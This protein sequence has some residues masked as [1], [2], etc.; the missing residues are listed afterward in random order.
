M[1]TTLRVAGFLLCLVVALLS[2]EPTSHACGSFSSGSWVKAPPRLGLERTLIVWD[3]AT[4]MEHFVRELRFAHAA[5]KFGFVIPTPSRPSVHAVEKSPFDSLERDYDSKLLRRFALFGSGTGLGAGAGFGR[6]KGAVKPPP[7][8][9][10]E[11]KRVGD[12]QAFVL[13][14][15]DPKALGDWL[16]KHQF[17]VT[18]AGQ[19]WIDGYVKLGFH[20]VALRFDGTEA[21]EQELTSRTLRISFETELPFYPY[22][23]PDDA[24]AQKQREL[25]LWVISDAWLVPYAGLTRAGEW[26]LRRPFSEGARSVP[27]VGALEEALGSELSG[28][29]PRT[30]Q[31]QTFGDYKE[32]R[33]GWEDALF[34][35]LGACDDACRTRRAELAPLL[36]QRLAE[37][38][39]PPLGVASAPPASS[40]APAASARQLSCAFGGTSSAAPWLIA[41]ALWALRRRSRRF[42]WLAPLLLAC[43]RSPAPA[44]PATG[45]TATANPSAAQSAAGLAPALPSVFVPPR[46]PAERKVALADV[47]ANRFDG[48]VPVWSTPSE[49]GMGAVSGTHD[50]AWPETATLAG[51]CIGALETAVTFEADLDDKGGVKAARALGPLT[52]RARSCLE[53]RVRE[54]VFTPEG[55]ERTERTF[56]YFGEQSAEALRV[57]QSMVQARR[58]FVPISTASFEIAKLVAGPG[59]PEAVVRRVI[60]ARAGQFLAC[61]S[62]S[63]E[64]K[65]GATLSARFQI[66]AEG[67]VAGESATAQNKRLG[68]C[69]ARLLGGVRFPKPE[70]PISVEVV[71]RF[72]APK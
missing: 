16:E 25:A 55:G 32:S 63:G 51:D 38:A 22:R 27:F 44:P 50:E 37:T 40:G 7:V 41:V 33:K 49:G 53:Q 6:G 1:S 21:A 35:P 11:Q 9:V 10:V 54:T 65:P 66:D 45:A 64:R 18:E 2:H 46:A 58:R 31:V 59:L 68:A 15:T 67:H 20:F 71:V 72:P 14:A 19:R 34:V 56:G 69:A 13:A 4:R 60:R 5:G 48:Y 52:A 28:L 24:P 23:E 43:D 26:K 8:Q 61:H 42:L 62:E 36:D 29:L 3:S 12:F 47:L 39:A 17:Q 57:S 70:R 30:R